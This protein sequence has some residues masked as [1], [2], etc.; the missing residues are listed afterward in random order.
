[1]AL[2]LGLILGA[3]CI[4][5]EP[6]PFLGLGLFAW[7]HLPTTRVKSMPNSYRL[8]QIPEQNYVFLEDIGHQIR[9]EL[10]HR[11]RCLGC[12]FPV[13]AASPLVSLT[14]SAC[15]RFREI[16]L[17]HN[18]NEAKLHESFLVEAWI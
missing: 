11:L 10:P 1:M 17:I 7:S 16:S 4:T 15:G 12:L 14:L 9:D 8:L 13:P 3:F 6:D 2:E 5:F 18:V